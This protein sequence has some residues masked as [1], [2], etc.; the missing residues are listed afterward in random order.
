MVLTFHVKKRAG[1]IDGDA[2]ASNMELS[3][4]RKKWGTLALVP[5]LI[6]EES[7]RDMT[8]IRAV[9]QP[10]W[11]YFAQR[12]TL[13]QTP[14]HLMDLLIREAST[15]SWQEELTA[16]IELLHDQ[17]TFA[18]LGLDSDHGQN[19]DDDAI[20]MKTTTAFADATLG[21]LSH[22]TA[23]LASSVA[24]PPRR[25]AGCLSQDT[26][27]ALSFVKKMQ[28]DF[29]RLLRAESRGSDAELLAAIS[30]RTHVVP[31]MVYLE[32]ERVDFSLDEAP[33][34]ML[35]GILKG[36]P[37]TKVVEDVHQKLRDEKRGQRSHRSG[38][39]RR[40]TSCIRSN[41]LESRNIRCNQVANE[42]IARLSD[43]TFRRG[44][45]FAKETQAKL[46]AMSDHHKKVLQPSSAP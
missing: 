30:W 28:S 32:F 12:E 27:V 9:V 7:I 13:V 37:D 1:G 25:Y 10:L 2:D 42:T 11:R 35:S 20:A 15:D 44:S 23:S 38:P 21:L 46:Q 39:V 17:T 24:S 31:R 34:R 45:S 19:P 40:M 43:S 36:I 14:Q 6:T 5:K 33:L 18:Q 29:K 4:A 3:E 26:A 16:I 41:V 8:L 22:R